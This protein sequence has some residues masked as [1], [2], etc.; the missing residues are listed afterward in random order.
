MHPRFSTILLLQMLVFAGCIA[1]P[2]AERPTTSLGELST[3]L[4]RIL[5]RGQLPV[6]PENEMQAEALQAP[7]RGVR[8]DYQVWLDHCIEYNRKLETQQQYTPL[9][10]VRELK[11]NPIETPWRAA[12]WADRVTVD[13]GKTALTTADAL[14][15]QLTAT[16]TNRPLP[17]VAPTFDRF[18][19]EFESA[20]ATIAEKGWATVPAAERDLLQFVLPWLCHTGRNFVN[21]SQ[22]APTYFLSRTFSPT[23][24][25]TP[26]SERT[27]QFNRAVPARLYSMTGCYHYLRALA[28]EPVATTGI[29]R[30][31][32]VGGSTLHPQFIAAFSLAACRQALH[33][34]T[35]ALRPES[36]MRWRRDLLAR[37]PL[38]QLH[39]PGVQGSLVAV[40]DT[41]H[42]RVIVGGPGPNRYENVDAAVIVDLGGDDDYIHHGTPERLLRYPVRLV[43]DFDGDDLYRTRGVGGPGSGILGLG[44]CLDLAGNDRYCQGLAPGFDP[45]ARK[46]NDLLKADPEGDNTQL[47]PFDALYADDK[48]GVTLDAGF[49]FG[50]GFLGIGILHDYAGDDLYLGQKYAFG[51]GFWKGVGILRDDGGDDVYAAGNAALGSGINSAIGLLDDRGGNDHYQC[52]GLYESGYSAGHEWD[53]GYDGGGI[54][55]GS[56]WRAEARSSKPTHRWQATFGGGIGLLRDHAGNDEYVAG[57][58]AVGSGYAGGVGMVMDDA[59]DDTYFVKRG[60]DGSNHNGWSGNHAL[61]NGCHRGV[62][63]ILDRDGNDRYSAGNLG[64]GTA[65]D[66]ASG[67]LLDL[68]GDDAMLDLHGKNQAGKTGMGMA[69]AFAVSFHAGGRDSYRRRTLGSARDLVKNYPGKAGNFS[70]FFDIGAETDEYLREYA[71]D[72]GMLN[73]VVFQEKDGTVDPQGIGIFLDTSDWGERP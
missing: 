55:Y 16:A 43:I 53:N 30:D 32:H 38:K 4:E 36:M 20:A 18:L 34:L 11:E 73:G 14:L 58:F 33:Q 21:Q 19:A 6:K 2:T 59:G 65:W 52:L 63:Y 39:I 69:K 27:P 40:R 56:S 64:G 9:A 8:H 54:G 37:P 45:R 24:P 68:G 49:A 61:G 1:T 70:F 50:A 42:G 3:E 44:I 15:T 12:A 25:F 48:G 23:D 17:T 47:V 62:G 29:R 10:I 13:R 35:P 41:P 28:G 72:T 51:S 66:M 67:F 46:I 57:S 5:I 26:G 60:P 71:N 7:D 31:R 22:D